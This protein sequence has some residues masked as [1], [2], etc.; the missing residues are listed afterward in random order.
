MNVCPA[1]QN[2]IVFDDFVT[3][4]QTMLAMKRLFAPLNK[5]IVFVA[6]INNKA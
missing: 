6:G 2:I 3:T 5:N 1:E 4:G